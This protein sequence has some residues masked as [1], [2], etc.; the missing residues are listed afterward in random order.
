M[1]RSSSC[2]VLLAG[3]VL[4][5]GML[6]S[7]CAVKEATMDLWVHATPDPETD[8]MVTITRV[9]DKRVF[10]DASKDASVPSL[11]TKDMDNKGLAARA[12]ARQRNTYGKA[13]GY[14]V[15]PEGRTVEMVVKE[16][17]EK[18]FRDAGYKVIPADQNTDNKAIPVEADIEQFW[19]WFTPGFSTISLEFETKVNIKGDI[20]TIKDG[21]MVRGYTINRGFAAH[22]Q[23]WINTLVEGSNNFMAEATKVIG[24]Q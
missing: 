3:L 6:S 22:T 15:L 1:I 17:L 2:C 23:A 4:V 13:M 5:T 16:A 12:I 24:Q 8:R 10:D 21:V 19:A 11:K 20:P 14:I 7:G 9:T 18:S